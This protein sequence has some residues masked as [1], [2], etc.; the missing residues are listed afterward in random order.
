MA[1]SSLQRRVLGEIVAYARREHLA[2]GAH[3]REIQLADVVGTSRFPVQAAL[4]HLQKL[5]VVRHLNHRGFFLA[6]DASALS[7]LARD[8][9]SSAEN[10]LYLKL[11][12]CRLNKDLPDTVTESELIRRFATSRGALRTVLSRIQQEGWVERLLGH[13]WFFLPLIDS[14]EAYEESYLFRLTVEP[15]G[16][17]S[18]AF[19]ADLPAL[20][21][22]RKQQEFIAEGG[23]RTMTPVELFEANTRFHETVAACSGNRFILQAVRRLNQLRRL[24]EYRQAK[25]RLARQTHAKE[26]LTILEKL[27]DGDFLSAA[28]LMR[29]HLDNARRQKALSAVFRAPSS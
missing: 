1:L 15:A 28:T 2:A 12:E 18:P 8:W 14:N 27:G 26:H 13:G 21:A 3:L 11:A 20:D 29:M 10:P 23:Y 5:G 4:S 7:R 6:V 25:Q 19:R 22:C 17:L 24:V 16:I 9:S